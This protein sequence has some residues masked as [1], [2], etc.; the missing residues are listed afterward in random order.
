MTTLASTLRAQRGW[1]WGIGL[2]LA[3]ACGN[4]TSAPHATA[5]AEDGGEAPVDA[6][7]GG[8]ANAFGGTASG[9]ASGTGGVTLN[10]SGTSTDTPFHPDFGGQGA[11]GELPDVGAFSLCIYP[12]DIPADWGPEVVTDDQG[13]ECTVGVLGDFSFKACLYELLDVTPHDVDPFTGGHSHC[14]YKSR[15]K[16]CR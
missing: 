4:V 14:C 13:H 6:P 11:G 9:A 7:T 1:L 16:Y 5:S 3:L 12:E 10:I 8:K 15:G 2:L